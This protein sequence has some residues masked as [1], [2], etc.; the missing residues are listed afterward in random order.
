MHGNRQG[1]ILML[2]L[3]RSSRFRVRRARLDHSRPVPCPLSSSRSIVYNS[4]SL[5]AEIDRLYVNVILTLTNSSRIMDDRVPTCEP[6]K[7][8]CVTLVLR[9]EDHM[10]VSQNIS[11]V[12]VNSNGC[13][14]C[15]ICGACLLATYRMSMYMDFM[16]MYP[17]N[18][19]FIIAAEIMTCQ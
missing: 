5:I 12:V 14:N 11:L 2:R 1:R 10:I 3:A 8:V 4:R 13:V 17:L 16:H 9:A 18:M 7:K 15:E 6:K 19:V